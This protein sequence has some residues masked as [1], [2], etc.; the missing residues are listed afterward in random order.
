VGYIL[1]CLNYSDFHFAGIDVLY[2]IYFNF[3]FVGY[4][5]FPV[6]L[7]IFKI[8]GYRYFV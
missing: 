5:H 3:Q 4:I 7:F 2:F 8:A 1:F 6:D